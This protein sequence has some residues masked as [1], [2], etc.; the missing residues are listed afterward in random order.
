[1]PGKRVL[2]VGQCMADNGSLTRLLRGTFAADVVP[3]D[4]SREALERLKGGRFDLVLVNRVFDANGEAGLDLI[5][6]VKADE[7]LRDV[8]VMLV[9]NYPEAQAEAVAAGALPGFGKA[10]LHRP[11]TADLLRPFLREPEA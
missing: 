11:D 2:S 6:A 3:L 9:S 10:A 1:M 5:R 7:A 8:P 4:T